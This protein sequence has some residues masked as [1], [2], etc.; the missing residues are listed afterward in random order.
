MRSAL[1]AARIDHIPKDEQASFASRSQS[2][3]RPCC[4]SRRHTSSQTGIEE[5]TNRRNLLLEQPKL[6]QP[7]LYHIP[8]CS[9]TRDR[10]A[11]IHYCVEH[12]LLGDHPK[13]RQCSPA[14]LALCASAGKER[15][16]KLSGSWSSRH[17]LASYCAP[18]LN[19]MST[20]ESGWGGACCQHLGRVQIV[21]ACR[22]V[23]HVPMSTFECSGSAEYS[24]EQSLSGW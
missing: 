12:P 10:R 1:V 16:Q 20:S 17:H 14:A 7:A 24:L 8:C 21:Q 23:W 4:S 5:S 9:S 3:P 22:Q 2:W 11:H 6:S 19:S 18:I 13:M 15:S